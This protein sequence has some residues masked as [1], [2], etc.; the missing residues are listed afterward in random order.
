[1]PDK[2]LNFCLFQVIRDYISD[3]KKENEEWKQLLNDHKEEYKR[4][5][6]E[7]KA[8]QR[9][10]VKLRDLS[11]LPEEDRVALDAIPDGCQLANQ[12]LQFEKQL[13]MKENKLS[14]EIKEVKRK[15]EEAEVK[16][17]EFVKKIKIISDRINQREINVPES[18]FGKEVEKFK[19]ELQGISS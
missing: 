19:M 11:L 14:A 10:E 5:R 13:K 9:G 17:E 6:S 3:L 8:V 12:V 15:V 16:N 2:I 4:V 1:M 18:D 7:K